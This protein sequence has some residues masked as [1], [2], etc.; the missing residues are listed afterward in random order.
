MNNIN[1]KPIG[2]EKVKSKQK[3]HIYSTL[4]ERKPLMH[5]SIVYSDNCKIAVV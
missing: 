1:T 3:I 5:I 2:I 4:Y